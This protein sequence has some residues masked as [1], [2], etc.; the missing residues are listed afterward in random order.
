M[1]V[2]R[3]GDYEQ[4]AIDFL[5]VLA[6]EVDVALKDSGITD[7]ATRRNVVDRFCF[8]M[9]NFIDQY[10]FHSEGKKYYPVVCFSE[11]HLD[12]DP[13]E[14]GLPEMFAYHEYAT[15]AFDQLTQDGGDSYQV[16]VGLVGEDEPS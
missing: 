12:E 6:M 7:V 1:K 15:G 3:S 5:S 13:A 2:V 11:T 10:W 9:G 8:G 14:I 16:Q 4:V